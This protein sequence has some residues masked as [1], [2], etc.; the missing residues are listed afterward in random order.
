MKGT[1]Q[2]PCINVKTKHISV[3]LNPGS[4]YD[5]RVKQCSVLFGLANKVWSSFLLVAVKLQI[6]FVKLFFLI[7]NQPIQFL[8]FYWCTG[9]SVHIMKS[10]I[11]NKRIVSLIVILKSKN[12]SLNINWEPLAARVEFSPRKDVRL[13][14]TRGICSQL[15]LKL[16]HHFAG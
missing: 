14:G 2:Q 7:L 10:K 4:I 5:C 11:E 8:T 9:K 16:L 13:E 15:P 6:H 12:T 3:T 1:N